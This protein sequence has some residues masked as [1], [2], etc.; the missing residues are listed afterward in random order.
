LSDLRRQKQAYRHDPANGV[1][2]DCNRTAIACVLGVERDELPHVHRDMNSEE[3]EAFT[4]GFLA[5]RGLHLISVPVNA[6]S[7]SEAMLFGHMRGGGIPFILGGQS[8]RGV[9]HSVVCFSQDDLHDPGN[10][11][12]LSNTSRNEAED[13]DSV[14]PGSNPGSPATSNP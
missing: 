10:D 3:F 5:D 14:S 2:G 9:N 7:V 12:Y 6:P 11:V 13:S 8:P 4:K 1:F